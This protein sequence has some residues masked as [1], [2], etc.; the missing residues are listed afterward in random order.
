[1]TSPYR[2]PQ[3]SPSI[4]QG[5]AVFGEAEARINNTQLFGTVF[6][7]FASYI[8]SGLIRSYC[9][10]GRYCSI[11]RD[12]TIGLANHDSSV[13]STNPWF[14]FPTDRS[15]MR[16]ANEEPKRRV[17]IGHDVWIGDGVRIM[18]GIRI[19]TGAIIGAG[20]IVTRDVPAY[21]V[22]VGS[23]ARLVK[24]RFDSVTSDRLLASRWWELDPHGL[25]QVVS[26]DVH[27]SLNALAQADL[28]TYP[29]TYTRLT[30]PKDKA[31]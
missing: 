4:G 30:P 25:R 21:G 22:V 11:G 16:L 31:P 18:S 29:T 23:P 3:I 27:A 1:M 6:F 2:P 9:E 17:I 5:W 12:V 15:Q 20:S 10:I 14:T 28:P 8:N 7:G 19:G 13:I 26:K 24:Q